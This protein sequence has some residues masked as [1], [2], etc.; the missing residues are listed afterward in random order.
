MAEAAVHSKEVVLLSVIHCLLL[1]PLFVRILCLVLVLLF[2]ISYPSSLPIILMG[3]S[4]QVAL[5]E[6]SFRCFVTVLWPFLTMPLVGLQYVNV[7]F[8]GHTHLLL[9]LVIIRQFAP[10]LI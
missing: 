8:P 3:K 10:S 6:L 5:L 7:V 9:Y 1:Q 4:E 2:S